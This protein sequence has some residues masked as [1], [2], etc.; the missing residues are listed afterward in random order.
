MNKRVNIHKTSDVLIKDCE[1][2]HTDQKKNVSFIGCQRQTKT[3]GGFSGV[4]P[5]NSMFNLID[6]VVGD[7]LKNKIIV[8]YFIL[9]HEVFTRLKNE[10]LIDW[11]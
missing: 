4:F 9:Q 8:Y 10:G 5:V 6:S 7:L 3:T 11:N 2:P 1:F